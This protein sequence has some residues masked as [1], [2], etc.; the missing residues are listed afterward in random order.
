MNA[1]DSRLVDLYDLDNP[2]GNDHDFFRALAD[3]LNA[4]AVVDLGCGTG[5]LTVTLARPGRTIVGI[6]PDRAMLQRARTRPGSGAVTWVHGDSRDIAVAGPADAGVDLVVMS[7]NVS[8]HIP[9][10]DWSRTLRD[11]RACLSDAGVIAFETRNPT[12]RVWET[13][14]EEHRATRDTPHGPLTEWTEVVAVREGGVV[15]LDFHNVFEGS[16]EHLVVHQPLAFRDESRVEADLRA[17]G[18]V[19]RN[20]WGG[21]DREPFNADSGLMVVEATPAGPSPQQ[22]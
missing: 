10:A 2:G 15:H 22:L 4:A 11:V 16:G 19:V 7:G 17:A 6:D 13:W 8:Q 9:D 5:I 14:A 18:F 12:L 1:T 21:W 3:D 20:F